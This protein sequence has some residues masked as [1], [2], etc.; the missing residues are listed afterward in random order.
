MTETELR[1][2]V[3]EIAVGYLGCKESDGTHKKIIDLYNSHKPLARR[4]AV[5]YTDAW[6][7]TFASAVAIAAELTDIIPTECGCEKHIARFKKISAWQENDAYTPQ[8]GDYVFY[9]WAD[10]T[11][12][13]TTD[14]TG[15]ADHVGIVTAV[16]GNDLTIIE[17]NISNAVGYR[18]LEVNGRYI[19]GYGVPKYA[20]KAAKVEKPAQQ[21]TAPTGAAYQVGDIVEFTGAKHY[22]SANASAGHACKPGKAKVTAIAKG[23][24]HPYH[25]VRVTGG[26]STVYGWVDAADIGGSSSNVNGYRTHTVARGDSMW[27]LANT[28]LGN[29]SRYKEIMQLNGMKSTTIK[30]GQ[31]LKIPAK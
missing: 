31:V 11:D 16:S 24:K 27:A 3:V 15:A 2:K 30:I 7:S 12:F 19:R 17:G 5:K 13:A 23:A 20:S 22:A 26:G 6:C 21:T 18:K 4:Y 25:L 29:G 10:G 28:Y 1:K 8:P 14:N 9:D